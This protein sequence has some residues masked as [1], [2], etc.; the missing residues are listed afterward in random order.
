MLGLCVY[1]RQ[2]PQSSRPSFT[3]C[4]LLRDVN[5]AVTKNEIMYG[6]PTEMLT[7]DL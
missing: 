4:N 1:K 3:K 2:V 6:Q 5:P 7:K